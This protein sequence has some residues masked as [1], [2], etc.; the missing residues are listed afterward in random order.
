MFSFLGGENAN[1]REFIA[2]RGS[3][4]GTPRNTEAARALRGGSG[5]ETQRILS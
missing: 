5:V 2:E 4:G 1:E 3:D